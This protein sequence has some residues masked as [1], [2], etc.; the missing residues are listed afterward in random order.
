MLRMEQAHVIRHKHFTEGQS[1][2]QIALDMGLNRRTVRKYLRES[3][4]HR[5]ETVIRRQPVIDVVGPR[6]EATSPWEVETGELTANNPSSSRFPL[7]MLLAHVVAQLLWTS[8]LR[9]LSAL[10]GSTKPYRS[11]MRPFEHV[12]GAIACERKREPDSVQSERKL[13]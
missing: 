2:R 13:G 3:E 1:V 10:I 12:D 8:C 5:E 7:L 9:G 11:G 6:I 4:P